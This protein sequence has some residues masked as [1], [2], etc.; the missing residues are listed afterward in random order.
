M[1]SLTRSLFSKQTLTSIL[2]RS[3]SSS[4]TLSLTRFAVRSIIRFRPFIALSCFTPSPIA[5]GL[6]CFSSNL[7]AFLSQPCKDLRLLDGCDFDHWLVVMDIPEGNP[8]RDEIIDSYIKTLAMVIESEEA[9]KKSVYSVSTQYYFAFGCVVS[10]ELAY[11]IKE[12]PRVRWVLPDSYLD[13]RNKDYGGEPF[14]NGKAVPYHPK[15]HGI[16]RRRNNMG[17]HRGKRKTN[18]RWTE[19]EDEKVV[20]ALVDL[21]ADNFWRDDN[22]TFKNGYLSRLE[23]ILGDKLP[24][25]GLEEKHIK[26]RIKLLKKQY[27]AITEMFD[28]NASGFGWN[29]Q[30]N[31]VTC[32]EDAFNV[33]VKTHPNARGLRNKQFPHYYQL[34]QV[35]GKD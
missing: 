22:R 6:R 25:C 10:E 21:A 26:S 27:N 20:E 29:E 9:A 31:C 15:Y 33:W 35:F 4:S 24:G 34:A 16:W 14:I 3:L 28:P 17:S 13:V 8:S 5:I 12:L 19:E 2:S 32:D 23:S 18:Q 7:P 1:A 30:K 11:K